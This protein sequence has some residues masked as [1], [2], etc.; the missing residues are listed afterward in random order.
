[1]EDI[2][3]YGIG[4]I[5]DI[6]GDKNSDEGDSGAAKNDS[7]TDTVFVVVV[8]DNGAPENDGEGD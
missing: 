1:M 5:G 8:D 4:D 7:K 6:A 2:Y 3:C